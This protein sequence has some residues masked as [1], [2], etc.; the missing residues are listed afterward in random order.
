[1]AAITIF[2]WSWGLCK[3]L[4]KTISLCLHLGAAAPKNEATFPLSDWLSMK[5]RYNRSFV[6][7][8]SIYSAVHLAHTRPRPSLIYRLT[9]PQ[10]ASKIC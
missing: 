4:L 2:H 6:I 10:I 5:H 1:M 8:Y 7:S 3:L 9:F